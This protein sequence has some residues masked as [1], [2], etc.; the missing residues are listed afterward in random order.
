MHEVDGA[1]P[2]GHIQ[3][4]SAHAWIGYDGGGDLHRVKTT[5]MALGHKLLRICHYRLPPKA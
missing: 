4:V 2:L 1:W 5:D 3:S